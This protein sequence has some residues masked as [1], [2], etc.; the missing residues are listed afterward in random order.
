MKR[1]LAQCLKEL[2][3]FKRDQITVALAFILPLGILLIYGF[4]IRLEIKNIPL[5][6]QDFDRSPLS[7]TYIERLF[8][9]NQF[10][11]VSSCLDEVC[12]VS[13]T[14]A[15]DD[16]LAKVTVIIPPEFSRYIK[17]NKPISVQ[18]LIDGTDV[19][20]ARVIQNSIRATTNF[21]L[22]TINPQPESQKVVTRIRIWFNPGR[23]ESLYIV[24]GIYAVIF[25]VFPS[26]LTSIAMVREKEQGTIIQVYASDLSGTEWVLGKGL[27]YLLIAMG[28][29]ILVM[30]VGSLL[31]R[32]SLVGD[33]TTL[34]IG[35]LIYLAASVSFGL[36][37]GVRSSNQNA[38]VQGTAILGFL[39]AFL[40]SGFIYPI[41][42]IPFPISLIS[43]IIPARYYILLTRDVFVRGTGWIGIWYVPIIIG[44][45]GLI[46]FTIATRLLHRMQLPD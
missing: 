46:F 20:N 43:N 10:I 39:T 16:G 28:E 4:A 40:L 44:L 42:N 18:V 7:R 12:S 14:K 30:T 38:A 45:I 22:Q 9:T 11:P 21:F 26:M 3:Q 25:W 36:F 34:I 8:A 23:K 37:F 29:A 17:A 31:F 41:S 15:L 6:F 19:N 24:P 27:A 13:P 2:A 1:I 35:T 32:I 33:P 5:S